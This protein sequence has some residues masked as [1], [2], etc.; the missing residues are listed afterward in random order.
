M[1]E[2]AAHLRLVPHPHLVEFDTRAERTGEIADQ[3]AEVDAAFGTEMEYDS[4]AIQSGLCFDHLHR[5]TVLGDL[6]GCHLHGVAL[7]LRVPFSLSHVIF[8]GDANDG[9]ELHLEL[10]VGDLLWA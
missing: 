2:A 3:G 8:R 9:L 6:L 7:A 5:Q 4:G 10:G 1:P